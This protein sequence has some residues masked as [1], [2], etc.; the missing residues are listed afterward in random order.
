V[1][2]LAISSGLIC[3][4]FVVWKGG[5]WL[6]NHYVYTNPSF[7]IEQLEIETDGIIPPEVLRRWA[8]VRKGDNLLALDLT[9]IKRDL[10]LV[11]LIESASVERYLPRKLKLRIAEREP[12]ARVIVFQPRPTD[13]SLETSVFYLDHEGMVIPPYARSLNAPAFDRA[14]S[15]LPNLTGVSPEELRPGTKIARPAL[16]RALNCISE[17]Q[18]S[19]MAGRVDIRSI[20]IQNEQILSVLTEQGN[21]VVFSSRDFRGQLARWKKVH[22]YAQRNSKAIASLDLAV[23]NFIPAIWIS[24]TNTPP[25]VVRPSKDSPYRKKHV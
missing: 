11:P 21:E 18:R 1:G 14:T 17:F 20:D 9:R 10:E 2:A 19:Q 8:N 13:G 7:A 4:L 3:T 25:P 23:T 15:L 16:L 12:I 22:D 24:T 6:L 5:E